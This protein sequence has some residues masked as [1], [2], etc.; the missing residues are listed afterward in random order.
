MRRG[1][2]RWEFQRGLCK[3]CSKEG[4]PLVELADRDWEAYKIR[5]PTETALVVVAVYD[6]PYL[7]DVCFRISNTPTPS[8]EKHAFI[9]VVHR[10]LGS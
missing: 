8:I 7:L 6:A 1:C 2:A 4:G 10:A 3:E 9:S 5:P